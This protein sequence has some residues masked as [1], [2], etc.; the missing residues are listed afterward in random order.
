MYFNRYLETLVTEQFLNDLRVIPI[1]VEHRSDLI[2]SGDS[3]W[4]RIFRIKK[5][6]RELDMEGEALR[7][8]R[9]DTGSLAYPQGRQ[10]YR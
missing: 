5:A 6:I 4:K 10:G 3:G 1:R 8:S 9:G 2:D 7:C